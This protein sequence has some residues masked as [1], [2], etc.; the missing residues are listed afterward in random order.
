MGS[1]KQDVQDEVLLIEEKAKGYMLD[2]ANLAEEL[3]TEQQNSAHAEAE[4][5]ETES[6][7]RELHIK[8]DDA[9]TNAIKW[10]E[11][12]LSKLRAKEKEV[13]T[14]LEM[15][16]RKQ[17][18]ANKA[19]RKT[20][21]GIHEYTVKSEENH[22]NAERMQN[23]IDRLQ[24]QILNYKKQIEDAEEIGSLNLSKF[25]RV[26][27]ELLDTQDRAILKEQMLSKIR[28]RSCS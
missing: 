10:G 3:R 1:E 13:E 6:A 14:E 7:L 17:G 11:R 28:G 25:R 12:M 5:K 24:S 8:V 2:A 21:R 23:L 9:E 19:L 18:D 4:R 22:K 26:E 15:E 20:Q 16:R 27:N